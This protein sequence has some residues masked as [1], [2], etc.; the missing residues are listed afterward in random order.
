MKTANDNV[1]NRELRI[2][3][4]LNAPVELVWEVWT[5][6]KHIANWWGP[7]GFTNTIHTMDVA[8]KGEWLLTMHGSDGKI[9][10]IKVSSLELFSIKKLYSN[11]ST[12]ITLQQSFLRLKKKKH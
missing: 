7:N 4:T 2:T 5:N 11:T 12:Q 1:T 6:A 9:I 8:E 10:L 3:K